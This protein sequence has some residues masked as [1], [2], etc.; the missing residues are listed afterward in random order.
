MTDPHPLLPS[1]PRP[2]T[3]ESAIA[4][5]LD[6]ETMKTPSSCDRIQSPL[7]V[8]FANYPVSRDYEKLWELAQKV[9]VVCTLDQTSIHGTYRTVGHTGYAPRW[10]PGYVTFYTRG[11]STFQSKSMPRFIAYCS[12]QNLEW[13]VPPGAPEV[14]IPGEQ[15]H[16]DDGPKLW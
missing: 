9:D 13:L 8:P 10:L 15:W 14:A 12:R 3:H 11:Y 2:S 1:P 7:T 16:E 5:F 6:F 4:A